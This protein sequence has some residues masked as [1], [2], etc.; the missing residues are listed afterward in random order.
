M[1]LPQILELADRLGSYAS[2]WQYSSE[3]LAAL[4]DDAPDIPYPFV[5]TEM[6]RDWMAAE[7]LPGDA[8]PI[9]SSR[10]DLV[11]CSNSSD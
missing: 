2:W 10:L 7:G 11:R 9:G 5:R 8:P 1:Y 6:L 3:Q 4:S